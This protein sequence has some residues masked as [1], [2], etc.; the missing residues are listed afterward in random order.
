MKWLPIIPAVLLLGH[1]ATPALAGD[2]KNCVIWDTV[3][4]ANASF[5]SAAQRMTNSCNHEI[6]VLYC[7][8]PS[9]QRGTKATEC[10]SDGRYY[11]QFTHLAPGA[12]RDSHYAMPTDA[13]MYWG[14]CSGRRGSQTADGG[15]TCN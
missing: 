12:S 7:H 4:A 15:Y 1:V 6:Y 14:A 2:A 13:Q 9:S 5:G 8:G 10:G 11:Q 3:S